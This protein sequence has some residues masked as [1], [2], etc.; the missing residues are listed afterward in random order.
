MQDLYYASRTPKAMIDTEIYLAMR[1]TLTSSAEYFWATSSMTS[2]TSAFSSKL[3][4]EPSVVADLLCSLSEAAAT[5][6]RVPP[7]ERVPFHSFGCKQSKSATLSRRY[8]LK[9]RYDHSLW[10]AK[11]QVNEVDLS[12]W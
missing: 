6:L 3:F 1:S 11:L 2:A 4:G 12:G 10:L 8:L 9:T 7:Q 5:V